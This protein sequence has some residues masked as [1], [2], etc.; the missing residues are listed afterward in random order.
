MLHNSN[1]KLTKCHHLDQFIAKTPTK[2]KKKKRNPKIQQNAAQRDYKKNICRNIVRQAIKAMQN[3]NSMAYLRRQL[4]EDD[5]QTFQK[6]FLQN[7]EIL[8]GFRVLKDNLVIFEDDS[9]NVQ[10]RKRIFKDYLV[11]FLTTQGTYSILSCEANNIK[12]YLRYKN[13]ILLYYIQVPELWYSNK[14]LWKQQQKQ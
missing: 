8:S 14:A 7:I 13:E 9:I 3:K 5:L 12:E 11:W 1:Y 6:Y 2:K 10:Q 4:D